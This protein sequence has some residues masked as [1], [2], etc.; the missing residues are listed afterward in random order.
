MAD[1]AHS[2]LNIWELYGVHPEKY[3]GQPDPGY[4]ATRTLLQGSGILVR[5]RHCWTHPHRGQALLDSPKELKSLAMLDS[6]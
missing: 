5:V 3:E 1:T 4:V 2:M 6:G